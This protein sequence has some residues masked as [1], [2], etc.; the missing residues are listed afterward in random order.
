MTIEDDLRL[1]RYRLVTDRQKYFTELARSSFGSY[2]KVL[3][4]LAMA[5][6]TLISTRHQL[7]IGI[8]VLTKLIYGVASLTTFWGVIAIIQIIFCL[9]RWKGYRRAEQSVY[10]QS[11]SVK[12]WWW[13]FEAL[14]CV[15]IAL[16]TIAIWFFSFCI[17]GLINS[18]GN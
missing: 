6:V 18:N 17:I 11:P 14:Y 4:G 12:A 16:S 13:I 7:G 3:T 1:E 9:S 10:D 8:P 2:V 5:S 15:F